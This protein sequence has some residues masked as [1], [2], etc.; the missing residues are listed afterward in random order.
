[1][2]ADEH[3]WDGTST[4]MSLA[5]A[6][7][8][9]SAAVPE[10]GDSLVIPAMAHVANTD[11]EVA[12]TTLAS[13]LLTAFTIKR[14]CYVDIG[15]PGIVPTYMDIDAD[16]IYLD[17][18]GTVYLDIDNSTTINVVD[19]KTTTTI[20][21]YGLYLKGNASNAALNVASTNTGKIGV[22]VYASETMTITDTRIDTGTVVF[23]G[24]VTHTNLYVNGGVVTTEATATTTIT[25]VTGGTL[26]IQAGT[27]SALT[28]N[29]GITHFNNGTITA[30]TIRD[31]ATLDM[32]QDGR[33]KTITDAINVSAGA[34]FNDPNGTI[35]TPIFHLENCTL[36][37]VTIVL[38]KNKQITIGTIS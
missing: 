23:G 18:E 35:A 11:I 7:N 29:G 8:Y 6:G 19:C 26:Y 13:V 14:G 24:G 38:P 36:A 9:V 33:T 16:N 25:T 1:M 22:A 12:L 2:A 4:D 31:G 15:V 21:A 10:T 27:H 17:P 37:D 34:T 28:C 3:I 20:G 30:V 32:S 5:T